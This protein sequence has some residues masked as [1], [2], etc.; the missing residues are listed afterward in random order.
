MLTR[1]DDVDAH[2]LSR[3]GWTISAIAR[4]LGHDRKTIRDY[5]TGKRTAGERAPAEPDP[6]EPFVDYVTARLAEDPHLWAV[7]LFDELQTLGFDRSYPTLTRQIRARGLRPACEPCRPAKGRP[8]AVIDH[9]PGEE[10]QWDWLELP[11]PPAAWGLGQDR[12]SA[13]RRA[14]AFGPVAR[15]ARARRRRS[16]SWCSGLDAVSPQARRAD[17]GLAVRPD[18]HRGLT[19]HRPDHRAVR[20]CRQALRRA[21]RALPTPARQPQRRRGE[22]QSRCRATVL[23]HPARRCHRRA[24]AGCAR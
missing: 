15:A 2:A 9:P 8:V 6:F 22:G 14:R 1:E 24:G 13:G 20:R 4:H 23:A 12:A 19:E 5:L 18:G 7:T 11:D 10:T 21:G 3:Q 16:R 17:P